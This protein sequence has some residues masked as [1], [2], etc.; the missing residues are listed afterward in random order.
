MDEKPLSPLISKIEKLENYDHLYR[1]FNFSE[2]IN[3]E[4]TT[5]EYVSFWPLGKIGETIFSENW[6]LY[7][8]KYRSYLI[9]RHEETNNKFAQCRYSAIL[10]SCF[11]YNIEDG[12]DEN[13]TLFTFLLKGEIHYTSLSHFLFTLISIYKLSEKKKSINKEKGIY[14]TIS[15]KLKDNTVPIENRRKILLYIT[16]EQC[17]QSLK[18]SEIEGLAETCI[19]ILNSSKQNPTI[20]KNLI[21]ACITICRKLMETDKVRYSTLLKELWEQYG[22]NEYNFLV[23]EDEQNLM[24]PHL[25]ILKYDEIIKAYI[26]AGAEEKIKKAKA[27]LIYWK[28]K[29]VY[30][31][32]TVKLFD[33][34]SIEEINKRLEWAQNTDL[35]LCLIG[36]SCNFFGILPSNELLDNSSKEWEFINSFQMTNVDINGNTNPIQE[37]DLENYLKFNCI[38]SFFKPV[39]EHFTAL[40]IERIKKKTLSFSKLEKQLKQKTILGY[41]YEDYSGN[42]QTLYD[43]IKEPLK[44][45][46]KQL[47]NIINQ[48]PV[49]FTFPLD[50]LGIK[51]ERIL[52]DILFINGNPIMR[53]SPQGKNTLYNLD[54]I[55]NTEFIQTL[56]SRDDLNLIQYVLTDKG[57]NIRND[58]AH[59]FYDDRYYKGVQGLLLSM[60]LLMCIIRIAF[61]YPSTHFPISEK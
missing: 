21:L 61:N 6:K 57:L 15:K 35:Y 51:I 24:V 53:K 34:Q 19:D 14:T 9:K 12:Y 8:S 39:I 52:R 54:D 49:D 31:S 55:L 26:D 60:G 48:K 22:D 47:S 10:A 2:I 28:N 3:S 20:Q 58:A 23:E 11:R 33:E 13:L 50:T 41:K 38:N 44:S 25:N 36:V 46:F 29:Q 43:F 30:P 27:E 37:S 17:P 45:L 32:F 4:E 7:K 42:S 16:S 1:I 18:F 59:G 40:F 5:F 56:Y